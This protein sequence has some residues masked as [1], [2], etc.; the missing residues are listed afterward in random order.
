MNIKKLNLKSNINFL[1]GCVV[2]I[3]IA[4]L[5][6]LAFTLYSDSKTMKSSQQYRD[7]TGKIM[8]YADY[9]ADQTSKYVISED[10]MYYDNYMD[11]AYGDYSVVNS[12]EQLFEMDVK[13]EDVEVLNQ[14]LEYANSILAIEEKAL[15]LGQKG[16]F[17][18]AYALV[19]G[20]EY[21]EYNEGFFQCYNTII[22]RIEENIEAESKQ[23]AFFAKITL[24]FAVII[25]FF[26]I[27]AAVAITKN[28]KKLQ[29]EIGKDKITGLLNRD[30]YR[31]SI[32]KLIKT[33]PD[34]HGALIFCDIDNL[35][36][37]NECYGH[38]DGDKYIHDVANA[39][40]VFE[41]YPS[42]LARPSGD[43]FV[44]YIH[45]FNSEEEL[46]AVVNAEFDVISKAHFT[47]SLNV[48]EKVR[49]S[50]GIALYPTDSDEVEKL[51]MYSDYTMN[52]IKKTTKGGFG[53]YD[54]ST[55]DKSTFLLTNKGYLDEFLEKE[56]IDFAMQP[57]VDAETFEIYGYEALMRPQ[58]E[59]INT[60]FLI[61]QLAKDES[62]LDR[63]EKLVMRK[64]LEKINDNRESLQN[65]KV[66]VNSIAD[67]ILSHDE[68]DACLGEYSHLMSNVV[69]EVTEQEYISEDMLKVKTET[70]RNLGSDIA[71][72]DYGAGYSNEF[73]LL[74]G[75]YDIVKIDMKLVRDVDTD[76]KRQEILKSILNVAK[77]NNYKVLAEGVETESEVRILKKLGVHYFQ[78]YYFGKPSLEVLPLSSDV[79]EKVKKL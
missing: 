12:V 14:F 64:V 22:T 37:I 11:K 31:E 72:D 42:V 13:G 16:D 5:F 66:F 51:L 58:T 27:S 30:V 18:E 8:M 23:T 48:E 17:E 77:Y 4:L 28:F 45:G 19:Y 47:T 60:P 49:F 79:L 6:A 36:F 61:L 41:K 26:A 67:Q 20:E 21:A 53:Y 35:K 40:R 25:S 78:G 34:K 54:K 73:T 71:L 7:L 29:D 69:V 46:K 76:I 43:E 1:L 24:I 59:I 63:V 3:I 56:L 39:L 52:K 75:L 57:I 74:S 10:S 65:T 2:T 50:K 55:F 32:D 33:A 44:V 15:E 68:W 38:D 9:L 62:K 70:I